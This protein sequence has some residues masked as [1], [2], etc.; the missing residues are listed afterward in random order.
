MDSFLFPFNL[1]LWEYLFLSGEISPLVMN[2]RP[3]PNLFH[4]CLAYSGDSAGRIAL[5][6]PLQVADIPGKTCYHAQL[7]WLEK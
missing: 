1:N 2:S 3:I 7:G 4:G 6:E 5:Q